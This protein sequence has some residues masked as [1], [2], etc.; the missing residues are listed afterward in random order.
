VLVAGVMGLVLVTV[1][2]VGVRV[3]GGG[4]A[5]AGV[6]AQD[7]PG[8]V[9]LVPGYGG[10]QDGLR[11]LAEQ[12]RSSGR[13]V[14]IVTL[15]GNGTGDLLAQ[16]AVVDR[17]VDD[18]L[19]RGAPSVDV[20]GYSAGGLVARLWV[21]REGGEHRA[22]RVITLGSPLHGTRLAASGGVVVPDACPVACQ[23]LAPGSA[24]LAS[25]ERAPVP[26][27]WLSIW[28]ENDQTVV[29]PDSARLEGAENVVLQQVCPGVHIEHGE[30]P[31]SAL[32]TQIVRNALVQS[33]MTRGTEGVR[34]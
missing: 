7:R 34:C 16:V 1:V 14:R 8:T 25:V 2:L 21:A 10:S 26:V 33:R 3:L 31:T 32:V 29:P 19:A 30:L 5:R 15:P 12:I 18:A 6:P 20:I 4:E 9:V 22:R 13:E 17:D 24:L 23:Q 27:P 11:V 28:T